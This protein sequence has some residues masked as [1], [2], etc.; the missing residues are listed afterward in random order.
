MANNVENQEKRQAGQAGQGQ[1]FNKTQSEGQNI[2]RQ[3]RDLDTDESED[4][5]EDVKRTPAQQQGQKQ[6]R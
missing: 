1:E 2:E 5:G 6:Q 3:E 4:A